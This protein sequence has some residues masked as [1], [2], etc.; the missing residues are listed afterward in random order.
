MKDKLKIENELGRVDLGSIV[1][2]L[3]TNEKCVI[4]DKAY[5]KDNRSFLHYMGI[6]EGRQGKGAYAVYDGDFEFISPP[7]KETL[8]IVVLNKRW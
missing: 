7:S 2:L 8:A 1:R 4:V 6:I 5:L 3:K